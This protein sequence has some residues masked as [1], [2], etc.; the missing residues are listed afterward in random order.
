MEE[1]KSFMFPS[2]ATSSVHTLIVCL[3]ANGDSS[4]RDAESMARLMNDRFQSHVT[5][6]SDCPNRRFLSVEGRP[7]VQ[8]YQIQDKIDCIIRIQAVVA[9]LAENTDLLFLVSGHGYSVPATGVHKNAELNGRSECLHIG[10]TILYDYELF[11]TLYKHMRLD[12]RSFCL[13]DTCHSGTMLDLEYLSLDGGLTTQRSRQRLCRRPFSV[14]IS[15]CADSEVAGEDVSDFGGW[16][17]KLVSAY[18]D[19]V[20]R[21]P[22]GPFSIYV[23][24]TTIFRRFQSQSTQR[25]RPILSYNLT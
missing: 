5:I 12:T 17:G 14:C 3:H 24:F 9:A 25:S 13:I 18:L 7:G 20:N 6:V 21:S 16:G 19:F 15:A 8:V 1:I 4:Y 11:E 2:S 23:F 10:R 22:P